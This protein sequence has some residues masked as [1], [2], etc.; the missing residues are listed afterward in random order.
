MD[1]RGFAPM[2][3]VATL[4]LL[5]GVAC[6]VEQD[7]PAGS[8]L[9][10]STPRPSDAPSPS[11]RPSTTPT[12]SSAVP[13]QDGFSATVQRIGPGL[14]E[15]MRHSH[16]AGCPVA[17]E[18]LRYLRLDFVRFDGTTAV[19]ELV[20]HEDQ[21]RDVVG[22]FE[23]LYEEQWPIRKMRLVDDYQ[24]DDDLSMAADNTSAYNC[25]R[26]ASG[27]RWSEHAYG[28]AIDINPVE[29]PYVDGSSVA[30]DRG[31]RFASIDRSADAVAPRGAIRHDDVVVSAFARIGWGWGGDW[32]SSR[33]Y[34][35]FSASGR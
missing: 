33:D 31:R 23:R 28:R 35:H 13:A 3:V 29:N 32:T 12:S 2:A 6:S 16:R 25:R 17:L 9:P 8:P 4:G 24:G 21:A 26:V 11:P 34:Q 30:P 22:V 14:R 19:G 1:L 18:D 20:V 5:G 27:T 15:R 10:T 7:E